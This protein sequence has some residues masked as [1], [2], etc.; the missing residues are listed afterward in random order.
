MSKDIIAQL[1]KENR[2][3]K[4]EVQYY[5]YE[6]F[7]LSVFLKELLS[8]YR[9]W[10]KLML[11]CMVYIMLSSISIG[12]LVGLVYLAVTIINYFRNL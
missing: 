7:H 12:T 9:D 6:Q 3:L 5:K 11:G 8:F 2:R 4:T 10:F 1:E